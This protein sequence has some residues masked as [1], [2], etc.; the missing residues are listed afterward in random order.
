MDLNEQLG[1]MRKNETIVPREDKIS[2][3]IVSAK[4]V[5]FQQEQERLLTYWEFLWTQFRYTRK[6]WWALQAVLLLLAVQIVPEMEGYF[7]R[8][9][10]VGVI[11]C[12]FVVLMIPELWRNKETDSTQVEAACLYYLR[13]VYAA[14]ITLFGIVDVALLTLFSFGLGSM[15]FTLIEILSQFLLPVTVTACICF[16]MLCGKANFSETFSL[17]VC[18]MFAGVWW[19]VLM[20]EGIYMKI[21]PSVWVG[22]FAMALVFLALVV[23]RTVRTANQYW[24]VGYF[25]NTAN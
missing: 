15:G 1:K 17:V 18:L 19:L 7:H 16:S 21:V 6:R 9:R 24:E 5:Y 22:L 11:G 25:G 8:V 20:N 4:E 23:Y 13:Q 12:L 2:E 14:R 10:S 3:T